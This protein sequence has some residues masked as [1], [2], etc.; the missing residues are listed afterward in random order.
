M[1]TL[2]IAFLAATLSLTAACTGD[3]GPAGPAGATGPAGDPG[4]KGDQGDPGPITDP[5]WLASLSPSWGSAV[6]QVTITGENFSTTAADNRVTF[7]GYDANVI[8]ATATELV[9]EP[10]VA[11]EEAMTAIVA[12]EVANQASNG[13]PFELVPSGTAR[14]DRAGLM[15]SPSGVVG[16]GTDLYVAAGNI[17]GPDSGLYKVD[18]SGVITQVLQ[19]ELFP[20]PIGNGGRQAYDGPLAVATDGTDI[21][22]TTALGGVRRY[23]VSDGT[24]HEVL[25]TSLGGG[26]AFPAR[27][28]LTFDSSGVLYVLDRNLGG[29]GGVI[30]VNTNGT[31]DTFSDAAF[32]GGGNPGA[33]GITSDGTDLFV[34]NE[35]DGVVVKVTSP[36]S[37]FTIVDNFATGATNPRGIAVVGSDVVVSND[38][39]S[40]G[41]APAASGGALSNFGH[42]DGYVYPAEGMWTNSSGDLYMAQV[43]SSAVRRLASGQTVAELVAAGVRIHFGSAQIGANWYFTSIG[44][45]LF[46][47]G[48]PPSFAGAPDGAV[49]EVRPDGTSRVVYT[50]T[51]PAGV[52]VSGANELTVSD[53]FESR[54]FTLDVTTA[55]T[56]DLLTSS[57]GLSCPAGLYLDSNADLYYVNTQIGGSSPS[58]IGQLTS[59]GSN[60][61]SFVTG[62][63]PSSVHLV[64][65]GNAFVVAMI[66]PG[67]NTGADIYTAPLSGG[68][69]SLLVPGLAAGGV[70]TMGVAPDGSVYLHRFGIGELSVLDPITGDMTPFG[71]T[72]LPGAGLGDGGIGSA[73]FTM[74]FL[75]DGTILFPDTGQGT[76]LKVAP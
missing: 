41:S 40:L 29:T 10:N 47:D 61:A 63:P 43:E 72:L 54:I 12:V 49:L 24:V 60:N 17:F 62:L 36:G 23:Q 34:T 50:S 2:S 16:L 44:L 48:P 5:P 11:T 20:I 27:T 30:R 74:S 53:C 66:G 1:R 33:F 69:A 4:A 37:T 39:G 28:G 22:Y 67:S 71:S 19:A 35:V 57:D 75:A 73:S 45:G 18:S 51:F 26:N 65:A 52:A 55:A 3:T 8:S 6:T 9:V 21:Y 42:A 64:V 32:D 25:A 68:A 14:L 58:T 76:M 38:D 15:T 7:N 13:L 46:S 31:T 59:G 56:N 70:G